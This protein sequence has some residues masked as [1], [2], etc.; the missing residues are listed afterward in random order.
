MCGLPSVEIS[1]VPNLNT[2]NLPRRHI[3]RNA[4]AMALSLAVLATGQA[5]AQEQEVSATPRPQ[6]EAQQTVT[7]AEDASRTLDTVVVTARKRVESIMEVPMNISVVTAEELTNRNLSNVQDIY[8]TIAG[9]S[10]PTGQL[11]LRGLVGGNTAV[12]G[13]TSQFV[14]GIPFGFGTVFDV[15]SVEV[16]R[17]PQGTLWGSNAIGGTVQMRTRGPQF[18]DLELFTTVVGEQEKNVE[19]TNTRLQAGINIPLVD[20]TLAMRV[21]ASTSHVPGK[22]VNA[23]TGAT[24]GTEGEFLRTQL[25]WQPM[26]SVDVTL[27]HIWTATDTTGTTLAD[28]SVASFYL[29]PNLSVNPDSPWGYDVDFTSVDCPAGAERPACLAT[30]PRVRSNPKYTI[31]ELLDGW[32]RDTTN[33]Y[34]LSASHDDLFGFMSATYVG[35]YRK[36]FSNSLD[37]WSRLDMEDMVPTWI[38]NRDSSY[39]TTHE[40]RFQNLERTG[41]I[42]WTVG[43][44][45]DRSWSGY[46]PSTQWQYYNPDPQ[47]VAI[48]SAWNDWAWPAFAD[49]GINNT[50]Q[51]GQALYGNPGINYNLTTFSD[52][53][54]ER[55]AFGELSYLMDTGIGQ[56]EFTGGVR[57]FEFEDATAYQRSGIWFGTDENGSPYFNTEAGGEESGNRKK[58]SVSYM[59]N[60]D[61]NVFAVY[62]EGYRPGGNN[63][64]LPP[65]CAGDEFA[66]GYRPRYTS[67]QIENMEVGF[68]A[69]MLD[70]RLRVSSAVYSIDWSDTWA[71]VYMP[72]CGFQY[73][74][75]TPGESAKSQ[76][77]E[78]E[79]SLLLGDATT[80]TFNYGYTDSKLTKDNPALQAEA[81][82]S[83]TMVPKYN[84]YVALDQGFE[85]FG[86][87]AFA[88][89]DVAA[90]GQY[91][92]HFNTRPEDV[93]PSYQTLNLSGRLHLN[94][95]AVMSVHVD[96][97]LN[98]E[99]LTYRSARSRSS[100]RSALNERYGAE[101]SV[102]VRF[103]YTY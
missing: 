27:G 95:N 63:A 72:S 80:L 10:S 96:N 31:Y 97:V 8:R 58:F 30:A 14:D 43:L 55:A 18:N 85:L 66:A 40:L 61:V 23:Y 60:N 71:T 29:V 39:R 52:Y 59:P 91:K 7:P 11:V 24:G 70:R 56:F 53:A 19:G 3:Q 20:D 42:D 76:G 90:Y 81:G 49:L 41:G 86:R 21:A 100:T 45:Q 51:L 36:I 83:M 47:S 65:S 22:I 64:P 15:E 2:L 16:L 101:R 57:F 78:L 73:T 92:S 74:T 33:L 12:P 9:G 89:I 79:S 68:K 69:A 75:N 102:A 38:V 46:N 32:S 77:V 5:F 88:R 98:E 26:E 87:E 25:R 94:E 54:R 34:S 37:N 13:T 28:R 1:E 6:S 99:Y 35:S 4:L 84:A 67:D 93:S 50:A 82:D 62:S 17:G 44:F 103:E 48:F